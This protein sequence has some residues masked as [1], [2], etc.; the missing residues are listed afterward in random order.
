[1][2]KPLV[3]IILPIYNAEKFLK[4]TL[5]SILSQTYTNWELLAINDGSI[6]NTATILE[7]FE[8]K[9]NR[10]K[11]FHKENG[12]VSSARNIGI[13][14][15][16]GDYVLF[17]DADDLLHPQTIDYALNLILKEDKDA[18]VFAYKKFDHDVDFQPLGAQTDL[19][20]LS[21][22]DTLLTVFK[23]Q[24]FRGLS[25][26]KLYKYELIKD[27]KYPEDKQYGEDTWF[28]YQFI[29]N[30]DRFLYSSEILYFY[31]NNPDSALN[32]Q[33][34]INRLQII[35]TYVKIIE[36]LKEQN[37][38]DKELMY[39]AYYAL[40]IRVF[41]ILALMS[42]NDKEALKLLRQQ[43]KPYYITLLKLKESTLFQKT[44]Y[45]FLN[46]NVKLFWMVYKL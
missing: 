39:W 32:Q 45:L 1:M 29:K 3:S 13:K 38:E 41:E 37:L 33:F 17:V 21:Q 8:K 25:C 4:D 46:L 15:A 14:G 31:R 34:K 9:E 43:L 7:D 36:D 10:I 18:I 23:G 11:V 27:L 12:G 2:S 20:N 16:Q 24:P 19:I 5:L 26:N 44:L 6:D 42:K 22:R 30:A 35:D 40:H 28:T